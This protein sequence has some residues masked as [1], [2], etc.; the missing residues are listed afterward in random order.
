MRCTHARNRVLLAAA[1]RD[2]AEITV[3]IG[4]ERWRVAAVQSH[5]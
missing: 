2:H 1:P 5:S 3:K 4:D